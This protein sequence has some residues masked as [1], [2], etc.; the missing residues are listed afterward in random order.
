MY[1]DTT[2]EPAHGHYRAANG[3]LLQHSPPVHAMHNGYYPS[4][5]SSSGILAMPA[6][7]QD[8]YVHSYSSGAMG[9]GLAPNPEEDSPDTNWNHLIHHLGVG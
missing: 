6:P 2:L 4:V 3:T 1:V 7:H 5:P 8:T 9:E